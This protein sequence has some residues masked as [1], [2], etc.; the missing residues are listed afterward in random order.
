MGCS[1]KRLETSPFCW[2]QFRRSVINRLS[3]AFPRTRNVFT[4][5]ALILTICSTCSFADEM[6]SLGNFGETFFASCILRT[7]KALLRANLHISVFHACTLRQNVA[8]VCTSTK[9]SAPL[10]KNRKGCVCLLL[11]FH[12]RE[13]RTLERLSIFLECPIDFDDFQEQIWYS[14]N[15][16]H[17]C[18]WDH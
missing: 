18:Y 6:I 17:V 1:L 10:L 2:R 16:R 11:F 4:N 9:A 5:G 14:C 13:S 12:E 8:S 15:A 3:H 7:C